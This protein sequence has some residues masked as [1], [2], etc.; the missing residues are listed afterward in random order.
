MR[1]T[2]DVTV[3]VT[4]ENVIGNLTGEFAEKVISEGVLRII[5]ES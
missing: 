2:I 4:E 3:P 5:T 1:C